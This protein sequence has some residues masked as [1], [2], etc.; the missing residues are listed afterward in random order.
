MIQ[1]HKVELRRCYERALK[2]K[3]ALEEGLIVMEERKRKRIN[4]A[5]ATACRSSLQ[6][7]VWTKKVR[8][9]NQTSMFNYIGRAQ[10][11]D[12]TT[13]TLSRS[14]LIYAKVESCLCG[15]QFGWGNARR[16]TTT[17]DCAIKEP[18]N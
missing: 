12:S 8:K 1:Q 7:A 16:S 11:S 2:A 13:M 15:L 9:S 14:D 10:E 6:K 18:Q 5:E 3:D 4:E 17:K